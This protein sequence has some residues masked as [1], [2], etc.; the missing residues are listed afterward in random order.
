MNDVAG[1]AAEWLDGYIEEHVPA[2]MHD[3]PLIEV[4]RAHSRRVAV[5]CREL[6]ADLGFPDDDAA[7]CEAMG[8]LHD[9]GRFG[10]YARYRTFSDEGSVNHGE[11]GWEIVREEGVLDMLPERTRTGALLGIRYH[12]LLEIPADVPGDLLP[13][14]RL[15]R[16]ADKL[17]IFHIVYESRHDDTYIRRIVDAL[18][19]PYEGPISEGALSDIRAGG[20]VRHGNVHSLMDFRLLQASWVF[21]IN[22]APTMRR[23]RDNGSIDWLLSTLPD[24]PEAE[25]ARGIVRARMEEMDIA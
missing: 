19:I 15:I 9:T 7:A 1:K 25:E 11:L 8:V 5:T 3:H 2:G 10:Q 20:T 13:F 14:V 17:D 21:D 18:R 6:A 4:K 12:N 16:D 22:H 23:I 24:T